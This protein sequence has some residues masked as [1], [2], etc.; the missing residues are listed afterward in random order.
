MN[1]LRNAD[2]EPPDAPPDVVPFLDGTYIDSF[3]MA[4]STL[5]YRREHFAHTE[6]PLVFDS[7]G[8]VAQLQVF[9]TVEFARELALRMWAEGRMMFANST[10]YRFAWGAPWLDVMGTETN[11]AS[12]GRY[13]PNDDG[14]MNLRRAVCHQRPYLLLLN[15]VFDDF[16]PEW[17]ELYMKRC[18]FYAVFPSMFSHDASSDVYWTRPY[19]YNRDRHLFKKYIPVI[20]ALNAAGWEPITHARSDN[21]QVYVERYGKPGG[22]LYLTLFNDSAEAQAATVTLEA[23]ALGVVAESRQV[24]EELTGG[25]HELVA[26]PEG[27]RLMGVTVAPEDVIV[28][29]LGE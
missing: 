1:L 7:E 27:T 23:A 26:G 5:N 18:A 19:L 15:T 3:E 17:V 13:R 9:N 22:P 21:P 6:I 12:G 16:R 8:R 25:A 10:P 20:S 29:R 4:A 2:F 28:L 14:T 24:S 11:W